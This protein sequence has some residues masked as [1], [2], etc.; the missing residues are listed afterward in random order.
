VNITEWLKTATERLLAA[1][2]A[3]ARLDAIVLLSDVLHKDKAWILSHP[4]FELNQV[5]LVTLDQQIERRCKHEPLAYIRGKSEFYGR[6]FKVTSA[7]LQPRPETETMIDLFKKIKGNEL[8]S[9]GKIAVA[10][11][12]TGSGC[13][14]ITV[15]LELPDT[16]VFATE[17]N[18]EALGVARQNADRLKAQINFYQ[19]N[20]LEP[21][22]TVSPFPSPLVI[23]ANLPYIPNAHT[24]NKAAMLEPKMAIFG[25]SDGLDLYRELFM[26]LANTKPQPEYVLTE[27]LPPQHTILVKIAKTNGYSLSITEDFIQV[28]K[29]F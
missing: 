2:V 19:G 29:P 1:D 21:L 15:R 10:D 23:L 22:T 6:D 9:R 26:Q 11:I 17:I 24:I 12:G 16:A 13:L 27:S 14:A 7:T 4:E 28:F 8:R 5:I 25:G 3:T 18:N 20:L